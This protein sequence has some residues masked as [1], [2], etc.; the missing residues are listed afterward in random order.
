M[1]KLLGGLFVFALALGCF[2]TFPRAHTSTNVVREIPVATAASEQTG[3]RSPASVETTHFQVTEE[4]LTA[5]EKNR[6]HLREFAKAE[7]AAGG[8]IIHILPGD[9]VFSK[10]GVRDGDQISLVELRTQAENAHQPLFA[11][12]FVD[13]LRQIEN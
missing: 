2:F 9:K 4:T 11:D 3:G 1:R 7:P 12:R 8:W 13:I 6:E 5:L 10:T